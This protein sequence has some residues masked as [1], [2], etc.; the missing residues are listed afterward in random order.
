MLVYISIYYIYIYNMFKLY[1]IIS[2]EKSDRYRDVFVD[3][4][5][6]LI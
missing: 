6:A 5:S 2:L 3:V 4:I 1:T